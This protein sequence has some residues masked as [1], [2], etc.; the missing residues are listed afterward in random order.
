MRPSLRAL[1]RI[2]DEMLN[3]IVTVAK[4]HQPATAKDFFW[5][6]RIRF[7]E[8]DGFEVHYSWPKKQECF[9]GP[10]YDESWVL[11]TDS[12]SEH[13]MT[14]VLRLRNEIDSPAD[15]SPTKPND[16]RTIS[17]D[18]EFCQSLR[19]L[20]TLMP[21]TSLRISSR[22]DIPGASALIERGE[23]SVAFYPEDQLRLH[24]IEQSVRGHKQEMDGTYIGSV[25]QLRGHFIGGR[26]EGEILLTLTDGSTTLATAGWLNAEQYELAWKAHGTPGCYVKVTGRLVRSRE[27]NFMSQI[28]AITLVR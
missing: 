12:L 24:Q 15:N 3:L 27:R 6:G 17:V 14:T 20:L 28:I 4:H 26:R 18:A 11:L 7:V 19:G 22:S 21:L 2:A 25:S 13:L 10:N 8:N 9:G 5:N 16:S 23:A 1:N